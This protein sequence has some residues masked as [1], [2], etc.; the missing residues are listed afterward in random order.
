MA[1]RVPSLE[2]GDK[3]RKWELANLSKCV[4]KNPREK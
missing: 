4:K 3:N 2:R 1:N